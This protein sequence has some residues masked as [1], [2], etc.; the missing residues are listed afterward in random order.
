MGNVEMG[1]ATFYRLDNNPSKLC[2]GDVELSPVSISNGLTWS[3]DNKVLY[4]IDT[5]TRRV[6]AFDFDLENGKICKALSQQN[7][8]CRTENLRRNKNN[9]VF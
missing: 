9:L 7:S 6:D 2:A 4:Y 5:P 8:R 3:L 1:K